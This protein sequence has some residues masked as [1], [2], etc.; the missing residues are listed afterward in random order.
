M[1]DAQRRKL[2]LK[3]QNEMYKNL[4]L[5]QS[6]TIKEAIKLLKAVEQSIKEQI[7]LMPK[8]EW[9]AY[10]LP[11]L[12]R[13]V[14]QI[15]SEIKIPLQTLAIKAAGEAWQGGIDL[16]VEPLMAVELSEVTDEIPELETTPLTN[17]RAFM[18]ERL[19][20]IAPALA[21]KIN[22]QLGLVSMGALDRNQ[23]LKNISSLLDKGGYKRA[24]TILTTELSRIS[25]TAHQATR[26][27]AAKKL[28]GL[29]KQWKHGRSKNPR[30]SH[31]KAHGQIQ[32][33]DKPFEVGGVKMMHP[34]DPS[35]PAKH[36]INC[37]CQAW[38]YM[39]SWR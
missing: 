32:E 35:A 33:H 12:Q 9:E 28:P 1:T 30:S 7:L 26:K 11:Q 19:T 20:D 34:H 2:F 21:G 4:T 15:L 13:Q 37:T 16:L 31:L 36:T 29:K 10:R 27:E 17:I 24:K 39:D 18:L 14:E 23:A 25:E 5:L 38:D 6:S 22:A 8:T 3:K